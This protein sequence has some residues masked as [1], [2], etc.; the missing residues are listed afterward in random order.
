MKIANVEF[1]NFKPYYGAVSI[2]L[3]PQKEKNILLV[4]G[5]NGQGKTSF[6]VGVVWCLY[7]SN[8]STVDKIYKDE[9]KG[10]YTK[11]L[12]KSLNWSAQKEGEDS[13]YVKIV[14]SEVALSEVFTKN[15]QKTAEIALIRSYNTKTTDESF[16]ILMDGESIALLSDETD[17]INF[18]H[19]YLIPI[20][21]AKFVFF[22]A[23]KIAEI[24]SLGVK[25]QATLMDRA[26][27]QVLGLNTYENLVE[28]LKNYE[29]KLQKQAASHEINLQITSFE[30]AK[31]QNSIKINAIDERLDEVDER[32]EELR[33][34]IAEYTNQ[35]IKR[36]DT[37]IKVDLEELRKKEVAF[38]EQLSKAGDKFNEVADLI[39]LAIMAHKLEESHEHINKE[40]ETH[41]KAI[42]EKA[43]MSKI[44][45]F[46]EYLFNKPPLPSPDDDI[47]FEQKNFY[48]KKAKEKLP[49]IYSSENNEGINIDF[50]HDLD[51][52]D[53]KHIQSV[54]ELVKQYSKDTFEGVFNDFMR[55]QNDYQSAVKNLKI[56]ESSSKDE[57]V[58]ELQD[59][60][61]EAEREKTNLTKESGEKQNEKA[62]LERE[63][64]EHQSKIDSL[65]NK[66]KAS[67]KVEKQLK[68]VRKYIKTLLIFV[69]NQKEK[70][71]QILEDTLLVELKKLLNKPNLVDK[72]EMTIL[73]N[74]LGLEVKLYDDTK[75]ETNPSSDMSKG[76]QQLYI[77]ALLKAILSESIH[78]LPILIDTPL[79]RL[80]QEHRDNILT[81]Y[82]PHLSEQVIIFSTNTEI[83]IS[84]LPKIDK[85][86]AKKY[87]L[88]NS[89]KKTIVHEGYFS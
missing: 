8:I 31:E 80:D 54:F 69:K 82:Y 85:H 33:T 64:K 34:D 47:T 9:V 55:C 48:Y 13:F 5:R 79:G 56:A 50:E 51:K 28:D 2:D 1:R 59:R 75:K 41:H 25:D 67:R 87:R 46:A 71:K 57:F 11:F 4:G 70:K 52:S 23:E 18:V 68:I 77:S 12:S 17:K 21:I 26:F 86:I 44:K 65:L 6:L 7:G 15:E 61:N 60:K 78:D 58:Q 37:S 38:N 3:A 35:L 49:E 29:R 27:G 43:L 24:A 72:V 66:V 30:G 62:R 32:I 89:D 53:T 39:P 63:N 20:D 73:K 84:D 40:I 36:G 22:D 19:D 45:D 10:N 83:R 88:E 76:E 14:F 81:H 16:E 42:E 74:N